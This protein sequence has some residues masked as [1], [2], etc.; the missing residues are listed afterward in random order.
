MGYQVNFNAAEVDPNQV[1]EALPAGDYTAIVSRIDIK[2]TKTGSGQYLELEFDM[3]A[4]QYRGRKLFD[5]LNL[6][7]PNPK[8]VEIAQRQLSA[9]CHAT[10]ELDLKDT[11]QL[12]G[13]LAVVSI[14]AKSDPQYGV[15]NE[16]KGYKAPDGVQPQAA[17]PSAPRAAASAPAAAPRAA[18]PAQAPFGTAPAPAAAAPAARAPWAA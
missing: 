16:V 3:Q 6:W 12:L 18:A 4:E 13:K 5:R 17:A 14:N 2:Q 7:N 1:F 15:R 10:G 11:D 9:L 8:T